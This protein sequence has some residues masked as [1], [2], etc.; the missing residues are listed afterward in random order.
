MITVKVETCNWRLSE[1]DGLQNI[2]GE[3]KLTAINGSLIAKRSFNTGYDS[4]KVIVPIELLNE[5]ITLDI[6]IRKAI[7]NTF[8]DKEVNSV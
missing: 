6:K 3:Y 7:E 4:A 2:S 5:A 8:D 1:R